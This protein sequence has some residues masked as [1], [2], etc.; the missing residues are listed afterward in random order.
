MK[1]GCRGAAKNARLQ[2]HYL[3]KM[4]NQTAYKNT[5]CPKSYCAVEIF[6]TMA[7]FV[8]QYFDANMKTS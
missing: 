8:R 4:G 5:G 7:V 1:Q 2:F 3:Q 6:L